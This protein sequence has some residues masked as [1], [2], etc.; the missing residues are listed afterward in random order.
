MNPESR[1]PHLKHMKTEIVSASPSIIRNLSIGEATQTLKKACEQFATFATKGCKYIG[2]LRGQL[3]ASGENPEDVFGI[4]KD[5]LV[6]SG[7]EE[8]QA[9]ST[10]NNGKPHSELAEFA[11]KSEGSILKETHFYGIGVA[12]AR[13]VVSFLRKGGDEAIEAINKLKLNA[14]G[15]ITSKMLDKLIPSKAVEPA[16]GGDGDEDGDAIVEDGTKKS[17]L[18]RALLMLTSIQHLMTEMTT[19][20]ADAVRMAAMEFIMG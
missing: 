1:S 2:L 16:E 9:K 5:A 14:K 19:D 18:D 17:A 3:V 6:K 12:D 7:M 10:A 13:R 15:G 8:K 11:L 4:V 20:E